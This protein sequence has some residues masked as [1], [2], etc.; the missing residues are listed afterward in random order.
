MC[1]FSPLTSFILLGILFMMAYVALRSMVGAIARSRAGEKLFEEKIKAAHEGKMTEDGTLFLNI[2]HEIC[3]PLGII[4]GQCEMFLLNMR[5]G[6]Y[7]DKDPKELLEMSGEIMKTVIRETD[8]ASDITKKLCLR[9]K[10]VSERSRK[11]EDS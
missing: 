6:V 1:S 2:N 3:A 11:K 7:R 10:A 4:R 9:D 5:D 8:K